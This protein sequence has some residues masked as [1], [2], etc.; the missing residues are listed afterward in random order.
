MNLLYRILLP[1]IASSFFSM[2]V[3]FQ[4]AMREILSQRVQESPLRK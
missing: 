1:L 4:A 3:V 2:V